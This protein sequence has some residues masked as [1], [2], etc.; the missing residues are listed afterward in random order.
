MFPFS[1]ILNTKVTKVFTKENER[2]A[3]VLICNLSQFRPNVSLISDLHTTADGF[4]SFLAYP[5]LKPGAIDM[6]TQWG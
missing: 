1:P 4:F 2:L 6:S 3:L 5:G